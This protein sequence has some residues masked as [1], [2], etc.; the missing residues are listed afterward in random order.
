MVDRE[1][2]LHFI[3]EVCMSDFAT[4]YIEDYFENQKEN[5]F[6]VPLLASSMSARQP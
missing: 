3:C 4:L 5:G 6:G 2:L 1:T